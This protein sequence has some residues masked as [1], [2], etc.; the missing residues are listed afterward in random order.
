MQ[1]C[2]SSGSLFVIATPI[3]NPEDLSPR[4]ARVLGEVELLLTED[5]RTSARLLR[6]LGLQRPLHAFYEHNERQASASILARLRDGCDVALISE[7]GTPLISDP[8]FHL[9]REALRAGIRVVPI[10]G[11]CA[12]IAA[13]VVSGMPTD[14]FVFEGFLPSR[15]AARRSRLEELGEEVRTMIFFEAPHRILTSLRDMVEVFGPQRA[16]TLA[17]ELTKTHETIRTGSLTWVL[18][19]AEEDPNQRKGEITLLVEGAKGN[20]KQ[21]SEAVT[22]LSVLL[23]HLPTREAVAAAHELTGARKKDLYRVAL[24]L[25]AT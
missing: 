3:G 23:K 21:G 6:S 20:S 19:W 12:L 13:L 11:P 8:G 2:Q 9:V 1:R 4:A 22:V 16:V 18:H 15:S 10:P 5:T 17:R 25:R 7:A 14:R 24:Q